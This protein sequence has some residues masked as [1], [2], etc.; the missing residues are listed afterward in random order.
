[1]TQSVVHPDDVEPRREGTA[2]VRV[3]FDVRNGCEVLE[4]RLLRFLPGRSGERR[5][6]ASQEVMYVLSGRGAL[7]LNGGR[8]ALEPETGVFIA[9]GEAYSVDAEE[10]LA[11]V[12]VV[13]PA[14]T[15]AVGADRKV[16]IRLADQPELE[17]SPERTYRYLVSEEA[18]CLGVTQFVGIVQPSK[19]PFHS[20]PYDEVGYIIEGEGT[21]YVDGDE[22]P[23]RAGS[24][25]HLAPEQAHIIE[26]SGTAPMKVLGV[27]HPSGSPATRSVQN[28]KS[29]A[30]SS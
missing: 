6:D 7:E 1:V 15:G 16:T 14:E 26:N 17:A 29:G 12:S 10:E 19:V 27:F 5:L 18:G 23:L 13:A 9:A 25:F 20:H 30:D 2:E 3:T 4:Q 8:H 21:A 24:C 11:L 22:T 28:N